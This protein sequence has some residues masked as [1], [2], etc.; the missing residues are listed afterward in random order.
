MALKQIFGLAKNELVAQGIKNHLRLIIFQ[1]RVDKG[2]IE[3]EFKT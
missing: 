3:I 1:N 2:D